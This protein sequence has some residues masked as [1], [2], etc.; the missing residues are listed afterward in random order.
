MTGREKYSEKVC[1]ATV[2]T[3]SHA[4]T[5]QFEV[6]RVT[7][8]RFEVSSVHAWPQNETQRRIFVSS[9]RHSVQHFELPFLP[10]YSL[11]YIR[12][13]NH[14]SVEAVVVLEGLSHS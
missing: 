1:C 8:K 7:T 2:L 13:L 5:A 4:Y 9:R 14:D 11:L 12:E 3:S 10:R 6:V